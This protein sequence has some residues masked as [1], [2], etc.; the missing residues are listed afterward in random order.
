[1]V[2]VFLDNV[3]SA[4]AMGGGWPLSS[5]DKLL[6]MTVLTTYWYTFFCTV[7]RVVLVIVV[8][9]SLMLTQAPVDDLQNH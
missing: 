1:M 2:L 6:S 7:A 5:L 3:C 4:V 9:L 8:I